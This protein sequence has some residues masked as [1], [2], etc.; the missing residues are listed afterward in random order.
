MEAAAERGI[1]FGSAESD[2]DLQRVEARLIING[3]LAELSAEE[4]KLLVLRFFDQHSQAEIA[5]ELG[6]SQMQVSRLLTRLLAKLRLSIGSLQGLT[7][8]S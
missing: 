4:R 7:L 1:S 6:T 3:A 5:A 8:A 2:D